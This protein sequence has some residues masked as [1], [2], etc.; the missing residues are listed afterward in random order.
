MNFARIYSRFERDTLPLKEVS[1]EQTGIHAEALLE[2]NELRKAVNIL[3]EEKFY[4]ASLTAVSMKP[5]PCM[6]YQ[7]AHHEAL[8]RMELKVFAH[9][10]EAPTISHIYQGANWYEREVRDFFGI[11][12]TGH[13]DM[14][15]LILSDLD[16]GFHP[17]A[18]KEEACLSAETL[19][20]LPQPP[21]EDLAESLPN[22]GSPEQS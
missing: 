11:V 15:P 21:A 9:D 5:A 16:T 12:F 7:F 18:K 19:G 17:L 13:P 1:Y 4:L 22:E 2:K 3:Y 14:R 10:N 8:L 6:V 20:F